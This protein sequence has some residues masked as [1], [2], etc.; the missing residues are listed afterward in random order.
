[1]GESLQRPMPAHLHQQSNTDRA[2]R[3]ADG[4]HNKGKERVFRAKT[5]HKSKTFRDEGFDICCQNAAKGEERRFS[6]CLK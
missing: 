6:N 5:K 3:G 1:M 4:S 2:R